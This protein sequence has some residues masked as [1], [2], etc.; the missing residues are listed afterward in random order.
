MMVD[1]VTE[2]TKDIEQIYFENNTIANRLFD[3]KDRAEKLRGS[4]G[5]DNFNVKEAANLCL[6]FMDGHKTHSMKK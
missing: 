4:F 5:G 1:R 6:A 3:V 2:K